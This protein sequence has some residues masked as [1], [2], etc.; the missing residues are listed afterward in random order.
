LN[1]RGPGGCSWPAT[2]GEAVGK[3]TEVKGLLVRGLTALKLK[4]PATLQ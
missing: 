2:S 1:S 4:V 3:G